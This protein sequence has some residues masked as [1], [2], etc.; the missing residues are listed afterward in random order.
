MAWSQ[1][2]ARNVF[3]ETQA[4]TRTVPTTDATEGAPLKDAVAFTLV[5]EANSTKTISGGA[6]VAY[7]YDETVA[8]WSRCPELDQTLSTT[9][10]R[11]VAY[12][13]I[14]SG[15]RIGQRVQ[16]AT[17]SVTVSG[18]TDVVV[19]IIVANKG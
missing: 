5:V 16:F 6:M 14:V 19:Y 2:P 17:S 10:V 12:N 3:Y 7:T 9:G 1:T 18:G 8:A 13:Y 4:L 15:S 11:R